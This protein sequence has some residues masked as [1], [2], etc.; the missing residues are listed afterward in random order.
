MAKKQ[1]LTLEKGK[2]FK[3][4]LRWE[5]R[6]TNVYKA[7][8]GI[9]AAAPAVV[10]AT[11]HGVPDGWD[12]AIVSV[13]GMTQINAANS[14]PK[15]KDYTPATKLSD[16]TLE[17]NAVNAAGYSTYT[18]GGY[19]QYYKPHALAGVTARMM[20]KDK[21]GGTVL[22]TSEGLTPTITVTVDDTA[23]SITITISA[24]DTAA[25]TWKKGVYDLEGVDG[26]TV[27]SL[28]SGS[29]TVEPEVTT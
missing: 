27:Y 9:T 5:D 2:T 17:L 29:V 3:F 16:N 19:V 15:D 26:S 7:I 12:V 24:T 6:E 20:V 14:P 10:T 4:V 8:T 18:S 1:D 22:L 28:L 25:L 23:K 13:K 11:G 21:V